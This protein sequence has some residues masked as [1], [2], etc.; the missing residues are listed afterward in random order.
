M[1]F[2]FLL[3]LITIH[4]T[5]G[6]TAT[7]GHRVTREKWRKRWKGFRKAELKKSKD[8][9]CL[10]TLDSKPFRSQV[11]TF[12]SQRIPE[13][14][15]ARKKTAEINPCRITNGDRKIMKS[16]RITSSPTKRIW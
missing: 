15:C 2:L 8:K 13:S 16:I 6:W 3:F 1:V 7:T 5:P 11:N 14:N 4:S 12:Y 10:S 9:K